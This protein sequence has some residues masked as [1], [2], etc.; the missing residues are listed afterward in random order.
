MLVRPDRK[1]F[2]QMMDFFAKTKP[3]KL[4]GNLI[5]CTEMGLINA[6]FGK[7]HRLTINKMSSEL[8]AP[9][10]DEK[11]VTA[12]LPVNTDSKWVIGRPD[13]QRDYTKYNPWAVH[14]MR[15]DHCAKPWD[16]CNKNGQVGRLGGHCDEYPYQLWCRLAKR[17]RT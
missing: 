5:D 6:F 4:F 3:A 7:P 1:I 15:K 14:F 10:P 12:I 17:D 16:V 13:L 8:I 2:S 9:P 11:V